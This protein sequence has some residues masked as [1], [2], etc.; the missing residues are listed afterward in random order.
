MSTYQRT[1]SWNTVNNVHSLNMCKRIRKE[2]PA[3]KYQGI[4]NDPAPNIEAQGH[5]FNTIRVCECVLV[6][7]RKVI[8]WPVEIK[9]NSLWEK[10]FSSVLRNLHLLW[11]KRG[12]VSR[13]PPYSS[14]HK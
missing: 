5:V 11:N 14:N 3:N 8:E 2:L 12:N 1:V 13:S 4:D 9:K 10:Q 7:Q 6:F